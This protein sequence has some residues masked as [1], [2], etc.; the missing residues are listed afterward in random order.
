MMHTTPRVR[1]SCGRVGWMLV[2][3]DAI[4]CWMRVLS[5][6]YTQ[7]R[8]FRDLIKLT[9]AEWFHFPWERVSRESGAATPPSRKLLF[10]WEMRAMATRPRIEGTSETIFWSTTTVH[11]SMPVVLGHYGEP[12][13]E[14]PDHRRAEV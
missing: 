11:G 8:C 4:Y 12:F 6:T 9:A 13:Q 3:V 10:S 5:G 7:V 14:N 2:A 1:W